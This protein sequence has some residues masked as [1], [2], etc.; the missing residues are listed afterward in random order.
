MEDQ[1]NQSAK[2]DTQKGEQA[3]EA[4]R[5]DKEQLRKEAYLSRER[6]LE[7]AQKEKELKRREQREAEEKKQLAREQ[8]RKDAYLAQEKALAE[9]EAK[10]RKDR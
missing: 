1:E 6:A 5:L 2:S 10:R 9:A 7:E 3:G 8:A 4:K